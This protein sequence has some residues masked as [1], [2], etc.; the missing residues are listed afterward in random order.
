MREESDEKGAITNQI[1]EDE[2]DLKLRALVSEC[3][4]KLREEA[5]KRQITIKT[6]NRTSATEIQF[7]I[8]KKKYS[9][10]KAVMDNSTNSVYVRFNGI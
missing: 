9:E 5:V 7:T 10:L 3:N 8:S 6:V 1:A 4:D 2:T